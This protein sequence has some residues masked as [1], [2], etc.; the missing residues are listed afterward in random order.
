MNRLDKDQII[1]SMN[2]NQVV[3][4]SLN[5]VKLTSVKEAL[6]LIYP[7]LSL[8]VK[9]VSVE[10]GVSAMPM[11]D[12]EIH[13]GASQRAL[14]AHHLTGEKLTVGLEG[15]LSKV[16]QTWYLTSWAAVF[17]DSFTSQASSLRMPV[18][19][20]IG[21]DIIHKKIE[22]GEV[23]DLLVDEENVKQER[24]AIG[25]FTSGLISRTDLFRS[26]I[27]CAFAPL[28]TP[29]FFEIK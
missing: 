3:V 27:I 19:N 15:G 26:S 4:G 9:G 21:E 6:R 10:S 23:I 2:I 18:P 14:N 20:K 16:G 12:D 24:G 29:K 25:V 28:I 5:P 7:S 8:Q 22:L 13:K 11:T 1:S 17:F